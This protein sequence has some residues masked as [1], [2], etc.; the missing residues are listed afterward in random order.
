MLL[1]SQLPRCCTVVLPHSVRSAA[2]A[3]ICP[4]GLRAQ[5]LGTPTAAS[6][7]RRPRHGF[8]TA[9]GCKGSNLFGQ[10]NA[11]DLLPAMWRN[12]HREVQYPLSDSGALQPV[13]VCAQAPELLLGEPE[14]KT[15]GS[16]FHYGNLAFTAARR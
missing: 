10:T 14:L 4:G 3:L 9:G 11:S 13:S 15:V 5:Q 7:T 2:A 16:V 6:H 12:L 8:L 1:P